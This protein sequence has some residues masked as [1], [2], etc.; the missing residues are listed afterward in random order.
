MRELH[1]ATFGMKPKLKKI[2]RKLPLSVSGPKRTASF[3]QKGT[4]TG[5][6]KLNRAGFAG[7]RFV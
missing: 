5:S 3:P 1:E 6:Q 2:F 7:G 4:H